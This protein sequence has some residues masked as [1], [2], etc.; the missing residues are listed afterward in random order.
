MTSSDAMDTKQYT[1]YVMY[2]VIIIYDCS[3]R[4]YVADNAGNYIDKPTKCICASRMTLDAFGF[5]ACFVI[6]GFA[7]FAS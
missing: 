2:V 6:R 3:C 7:L 1:T 4:G 5:L